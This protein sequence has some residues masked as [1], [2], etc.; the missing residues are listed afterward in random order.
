M[1]QRQGFRAGRCP[2]AVFDKG[3]LH[4]VFQKFVVGPAWLPSKNYLKPASIAKQSPMWIELRAK[5]A[6]WSFKKKDVEDEIAWFP[7]DGWNLQGAT[8][9]AWRACMLERFRAISKKL[10]KEARREKLVTWFANI[11][12]TDKAELDDEDQVP[13][14]ENDDLE[15]ED[16]EDQDA[17]PSTPMPEAKKRGM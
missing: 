7:E 11:F 5:S 12:G 13:D 17:E 4:D 1:S 8:P 9:E 2:S 3:S 15:V 10:G 14:S 16:E 6:V